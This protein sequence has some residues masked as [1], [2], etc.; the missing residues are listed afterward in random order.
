M[1]VKIIR[2]SGFR[3]ALDYVYGKPGAAVIGGNMSGKDARELAHEFGAVRQLR[4]D[5]GKPVW[6]TS[7]S[8]PPGERPTNEQWETM[9]EEFMQGMGFNKATPYVIARH[10]DTAHDHIHIVAS[11]V[12]LAGGVYHGGWEVRQA[13]K[14]TQNLE[15]AHG[16][17]QTLGMPE[18]GKDKA[19]LTAG[20]FKKAVRTGTEPPKARLQRVIDE[21]MKDRPSAGEFAERLRA[22]GIEVRANIASTGKMNGFSFS[23]GGVAFKGVDL[24]KKY[25]WKGLQEG[26]MTYDADRDGKK[27]VHSGPA[28]REDRTAT[29]GLGGPTAGSSNS[30]RQGN[31]AGA[32]GKAAEG[33]VKL[34]G[35][36]SYGNPNANLNWSALINNANNKAGKGADKGA[37]VSGMGSNVMAK[38]H[39][40]G[41]SGYAG[42]LAAAVTGLKQAVQEGNPWPM[43]K[44]AM[45]AGL[46]EIGQAW[47]EGWKEGA[48]KPVK[49]DVKPI[50]NDEQKEA[51]KQKPAER[52]VEPIRAERETAEQEKARYDKF[53]WPVR[54]PQEQ[55]AQP[56]QATGPRPYMV[57]FDFKAGKHAAFDM[58]DPLNSK[59]QDWGKGAIQVTAKDAAAAIKAVGIAQGWIVEPK[60]ARGR[61]SRP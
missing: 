47:Q 35:G 14:V 11:R 32:T 17:T 12:D 23:V 53:F 52:P 50:R 4:P 21:A 54:Q 6:H 7:L 58:S 44:I 34:A 22:Q 36:R 45:Q 19:P 29:S 13:I 42:D 15:Q 43:L 56:A 55:P 8:L 30:D 20:E 27:L 49:P 1:I 39:A 41:K 40:A 9:A 25:T 48:R 31:N 10:N 60:Q 3:G 2:G 16:L 37:G 33:G 24:G 18:G 28:I 59:R 61:G 38:S 51:K 26:G 57:D 5:I 46:R